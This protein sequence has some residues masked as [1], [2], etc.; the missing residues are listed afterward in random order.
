MKILDDRKVEFPRASRNFQP[1]RTED[2]QKTAYEPV[3]V[4][5]RNC[6]NVICRV[7]GSAADRHTIIVLGS[8]YDRVGREMLLSQC[9]VHWA[10]QPPAGDL[11]GLLARINKLHDRAQRESPDLPVEI[12]LDLTRNPL[13]MEGFS[14]DPELFM[15]TTTGLS[16]I[17]PPYR[18]VGRLML[19]SQLQVLLRDRKLAVVLPEQHNDNLVVTKA[20]L[21]IAL[22]NVQLKMPKIEL[23]EAF[24]SDTGPEDDLAICA[25]LGVLL[26][27]ERM[28]P[29]EDLRFRKEKRGSQRKWV[30]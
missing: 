22:A 15:I 10:V 24:L 3:Y 5:H 1:L 26:C 30:Y 18:L 17:Q 29:S 23:E 19:L 16:R 7:A 21:E 8:R 12:A 25:G 27:Q 9:V 6:F 28:I 4:S 2:Q 11:G 20:K 14:L 13:A